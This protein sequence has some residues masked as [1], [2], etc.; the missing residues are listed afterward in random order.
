VTDDG[1][2]ETVQVSGSGTKRAWISAGGRLFELVGSDGSFDVPYPM[3]GE[4]V[5]WVA[6]GSLAKPISMQSKNER[7]AA[8]SHDGTSAYAILVLRDSLSRDIEQDSEQRA[9]DSRPELSVDFSPTRETSLSIDVRLF[10]LE[11][12]MTREQ[13]NGLAGRHVTFRAPD[14]SV[15]EVAVTSIS[16]TNR[17]AGVW[18]YSVSMTKET[19]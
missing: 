15:D 1:P 13:M 3:S 18:D 11:H 5:I 12:E 14:G 10:G 7:M 16:E 2:F 17:G 4:Y 19:R 6:N 9:L 8:W